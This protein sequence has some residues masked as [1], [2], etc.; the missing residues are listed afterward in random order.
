MISFEKVIP[1]KNQVEELYLLLSKRKSSISH[2]KVPSLKEHTEFVSEN[3][4]I[5]WYLIYKDKDLSGSVYVQSDNSVGLSL[6]QP[7]QEDV[8]E[9]IAFIKNNH[10][11]LP[12][13]K[14]L[15]RENF[16]V[17]IAPDD[18]NLIKILNKLNKNEIQRSF[19]I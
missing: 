4:Y 13:I 1:T 15:R 2:N 19:V 18:F 7:N 12:S 10:Q 3:P 8:L 17:N 9:V 16:F 6:N 11:P 14:S 5:E